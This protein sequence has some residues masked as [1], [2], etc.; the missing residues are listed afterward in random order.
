MLARFSS[1]QYGI[2]RKCIVFTWHNLT[3]KTP[4]LETSTYNKV[5][6]IKVYYTD[7]GFPKMD[8]VLAFLLLSILEILHC[9][10]GGNAKKPS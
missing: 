6:I 1:V 9:K 7:Q 4:V 5:I 2:V 10:K 3:C 8:V